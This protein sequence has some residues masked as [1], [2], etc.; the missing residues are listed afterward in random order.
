MSTRT[1][2]RKKAAVASAII[3]ATGVLGMAGTIALVS[4]DLSS[5]F[6]DAGATSVTDASSTDD[7]AVT[8][9]PSENTTTT[10]DTTT[11]TTDDSS[12]SA[13]QPS[14]SDSPDATSNGS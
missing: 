8:S 5:S 11:D 3:A 7:T 10:D 12:S 2:G 14:T 13:V 1:A 6:T 9:D 4:S